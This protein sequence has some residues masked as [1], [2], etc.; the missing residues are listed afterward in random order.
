MREGEARMT[1]LES[2][3]V[4]QNLVHYKKLLREEMNPDQ[5]SIL[6]RLIENEIAKLQA[7]AKRFEMTKVS[8]FQ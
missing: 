2:F 5:R 1:D 3:I 4:N 6:L 8:G 7:S